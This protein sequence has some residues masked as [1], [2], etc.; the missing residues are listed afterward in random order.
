LGTLRVRGFFAVVGKI[1]QTV[2]PGPRCRPDAFD[3]G[4]DVD[5]F[6]NDP[7]TQLVSLSLNSSDAITAAEAIPLWYS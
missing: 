5:S 6:W 2:F 1:A 3:G 7:Q 4:F